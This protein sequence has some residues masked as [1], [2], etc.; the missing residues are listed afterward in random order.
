[1]EET[2]VEDYVID[3][4]KEAQEDITETLGLRETYINYHE[5]YYFM[6][7]VEGLWFSKNEKDLESGDGECYGFDRIFD[8]KTFG[9]YTFILATNGL[10]REAEYYVFK[11]KNERKEEDYD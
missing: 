7:S 6:C 9:S 2:Y 5:E 3:K 11:S 4:Y 1:M 10:S 8:K